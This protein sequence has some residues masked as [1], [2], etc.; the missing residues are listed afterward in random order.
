VLARIKEAYESLD[1]RRVIDVL[2][3]LRLSQGAQI[4]RDFQNYRALRMDIVLQSVV[5]SRD[6][7]Q[8]DAVCQI[9]QEIDKKAGRDTRRS[10][11]RTYALVNDGSGWTVERER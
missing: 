9:T 11:R 5:I 1:A 8:V 2:P 4:E 3:Y 10:F 7:R 6:G